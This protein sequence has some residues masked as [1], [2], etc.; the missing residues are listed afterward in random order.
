MITPICM[1]AS[2]LIISRH[3]SHN[4]GTVTVFRLLGLGFGSGKGLGLELGLGLE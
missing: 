1:G 2:Y 4:L 3:I